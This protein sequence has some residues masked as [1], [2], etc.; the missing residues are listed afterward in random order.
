MCVYVLRT[1]RAIL[2]KALE[3]AKLVSEGVEE[4]IQGMANRSQDPVGLCHLPQALIC[5]PHPYSTYTPPDSVSLLLQCSELKCLPSLQ[6]M[7]ETPPLVLSNTI[8]FS[9]FASAEWKSEPRRL[10]RL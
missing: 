5:A 10:G 7:L 8:S 4:Q 6:G 1:Y 2:Y 9:L 3:Y